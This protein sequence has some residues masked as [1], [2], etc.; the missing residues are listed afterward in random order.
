MVLEESITLLT[1][2]ARG[3][4]YI[5]QVQKKCSG[6]LSVLL[7]LQENHFKLIAAKHLG[8]DVMKESCWG[9][10]RFAWELLIEDSECL[11]GL[12]VLAWC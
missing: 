8:A 4:I 11:M 5:L 2:Y 6:F 3:S 7:K 1:Y 12:P 10:L 9:S